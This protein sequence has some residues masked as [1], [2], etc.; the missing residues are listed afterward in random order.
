MLRSLDWIYYKTKKNSTF[1]FLLR[2]PDLLLL[3]QYAENIAEVVVNKDFDFKITL[4]DK[5]HSI[6]KTADFLKEDTLEYSQQLGDATEEWPPTYD[7]LL[8]K[9]QIP[10]SLEFFLMQLLKNIKNVSSKTETGIESLVANIIFSVTR[11]KLLTLPHFVL[12]MDLHSI[13]GSRKVTYI[14]NKLGQCIK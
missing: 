5:N 4:F 1:F 7:N 6:L 3:L 2:F 13:M 9:I 8:E 12:G 14:L 11:G 10:K